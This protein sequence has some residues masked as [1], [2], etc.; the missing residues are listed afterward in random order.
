MSGGWLSRSNHPAFGTAIDLENRYIPKFFRFLRQ[1]AVKRHRCRNNPLETRQRGAPCHICAQ[2]DGCGHQPDGLPGFSHGFMNIGRQNGMSGMDLP[3]G[4]QRQHNSGFQAVHM[5]GRHCSYHDTRTIF[6]D[7]ELAFQC[8]GSSHERAPGL[9]IGLGQSAA[10]GSKDNGS[11]LPGRY[12][13][14]VGPSVDAW[15]IV[16]DPIQGNI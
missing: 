13:R 16:G 12:E 10:P 7:A 3:T 5:L 15:D 6:S 1:G 11:N 4:L 2:M 14:N 8:L 9:C